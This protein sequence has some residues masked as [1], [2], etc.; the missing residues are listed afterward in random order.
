[1]DV[2]DAKHLPVLLRMTYAVLGTRVLLFLCVAM[3]FAL[4]CWSMWAGSTVSVITAVCFAACVL[5]PIILRFSNR[6][7]R[8]HD[9]TT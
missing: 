9:E 4:F 2:L 7:E 3:T 8:S 1:M 6:Q 5:W